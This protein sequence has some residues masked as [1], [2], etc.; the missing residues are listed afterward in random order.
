MDTITQS[1]YQIE[2][3]SIAASLV[4]EAMEE[5]DSRDEAQDQ[6]FDYML[7][8][9]IDGHQWIIYYYGNDKVLEFTSNEDAYQD[10]YC[11]EDLGAVVASEGIQKLKTIMAYFAMYQDVSDQIESAFDTFEEDL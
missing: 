1:S 5:K 4:D 7:H 8:E 9:Y 6:I 2:I 3:E 10:V 11:N